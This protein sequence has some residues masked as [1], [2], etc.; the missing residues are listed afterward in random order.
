MPRPD[1]WTDLGGADPIQALLEV[2]PGLSL[3]TPESNW[4]RVAE[5]ASRSTGGMWMPSTRGVTWRNGRKTWWIAH[6]SCL[7]GIMEAREVAAS[8]GVEC[9]WSVGSVASALL[10][11]V[12]PPKDSMRDRLRL[13]EGVTYQYIAC[14]PG[15]YPDCQ[16]YDVSAYYY[17]LLGR[18]PSLRPLVLSTGRLLW[19]HIDSA[20]A[21]RWAKVYQAIGPCKY[22]RNALVGC[23]IGRQRD[24]P[25]YFRGERK[26]MKGDPGPFST[27]AWCVVRAGFEITQEAAEETDAV[28]AHTDAV[29]A[30]E[31]LYPAVW[32]RLGLK[33]RTEGSGPTE[34][35]TAITYKCGGDESAYYK[36]GSRFAEASPKPPKPPI[37]Y[38]PQWAA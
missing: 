2:S 15:T 16:H 25:Y 23:M 32:D 29:I 14:E 35:C 21:D 24:R 26:L 3:A 6:P 5:W 12:G 8:L 19:Q 4:D 31:G 34:I 20:Q 17:T 30:K 13:T 27:A 37:L 1:V 11:W 7:A 9:G 33:V 28:W 36:R 22:L 38:Y 18:L 10:R